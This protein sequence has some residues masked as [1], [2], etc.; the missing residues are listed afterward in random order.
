MTR[1]FVIK[2]LNRKFLLE[3]NKRY[4]I[5][6]CDNTHFIGKIIPNMKFEYN[7]TIFFYILREFDNEDIQICE[8]EIINISKLDHI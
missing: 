4:D 2:I 5:E 6:I 8:E 7:G 1:S 3:E